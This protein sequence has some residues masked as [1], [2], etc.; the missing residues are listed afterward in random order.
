MKLPGRLVRGSLRPD[1]GSLA[2][3][4]SLR[5]AAL[6][7]VDRRWTVPMSAA[8]IGF[9]LFVGVAVGP[10]TEGS[11]GTT[12][13]PTVEIQ[14]PPTQ[15]AVAPPAGS[16]GGGANPGPSAGG[17]GS[18]PSS[19]VPPLG[20]TPSPPPVSAPS[21]PPVTTTPPI[22]PSTTG[23][24]GSTTSTTTSQS[25][26][27]STTTL[28]G[29]VVHINPH[30]A[31]YTIADDG[32]DLVAIHS[33]RPPNIGKSIEV[34]AT[35]LANGTYSEA[36]NRDEHG[37]LGQA[38]FSGTVSFGDRQ[39]GVYTVSAPGV[40]L[41]VRGAPGQRAPA[42]GAQID[43]RVKIAD[44]AEPLPVT[45]P[46]ASGCGEPPPVPKPPRTALE[47]I[48]LVVHGGEPAAS[49]G[50]EAIVEGV[51][52]DNRKLIVSADD[53]RESGRDISLSVP[54]QIELGALKPGQVL[55][56]SA[57][58]RDNGGLELSSVA[59]DEGGSGAADPDL[60]QP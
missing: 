16:N 21:L 8:A 25:P 11:Q 52:R 49:T 41:L 2:R 58:I 31:S 42:A 12:N 18:S 38:S 1:R 54:D 59:G 56:L 32:G 55:K 50:V 19:G 17:H 3:F 36:G 15:T 37:S 53:L 29:T 9:G 24:V 60:V 27:Q 39:T 46:G 10:G 4:A 26:E 43:V 6:P 14:P 23:G 30:A 13:P 51:C 22:S 5:W 35:R 48:S 44:D 28:T 33:H 47:Q 20:G 57:G 34:E 7:I 45:P 40:S